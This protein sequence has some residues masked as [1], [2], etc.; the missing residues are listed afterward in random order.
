MTPK[1]QFDIVIN[2]LKSL[3]AR[4]EPLE[5]EEMIRE[6]IY[7]LVRIREDL[8]KVFETAVN[9]KSVITLRVD[10]CDICQEYHATHVRIDLVN[11]VTTH[12]CP[13]CL[14]NAG[15]ST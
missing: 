12:Y 2:D 14:E 9:Y 1:Q 10:K 3:I 4:I 15:Y 13:D 8:G 7:P 11:Q 6:I 5:D